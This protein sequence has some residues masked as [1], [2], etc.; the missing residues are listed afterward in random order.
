MKNIIFLYAF[1]CAWSAAKAFPVIFVHRG[2]QPYVQVA[3]D[4][5]LKCNK[6]VFLI[7]DCGSQYCH[8]PVFSMDEYSGTAKNFAQS[9]L[10][11]SPNPHGFEL[12]CIQRWFILNEFMKKKHIDRCFY[13]DSDVLLYGDVNEAVAYFDSD[14]ALLGSRSVGLSAINGEMLSG[15]T[16][17]IKQTVLS[18]LA[19]FTVQ[20]YADPKR[21]KA[22]Q[23]R[24]ENRHNKK[25]GICDMTLFTLFGHER[26]NIYDIRNLTKPVDNTCFDHHMRADDSLYEMEQVCGMKVKKITFR[27]KIPY[28]YNTVAKRPVRFWCLHFQGGAKK[29]MATYAR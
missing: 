26:E 4:Q 19:D 16:C 29:L 23:D 9:Y 10:H 27:E 3:L 21:R 8:V 28:G 11:L 7:T 25:H 24:F 1:F 20:T 14:L 13:C 18:D 6:E 17:Y 12:F 15:G 5:A 22:L 2:Y